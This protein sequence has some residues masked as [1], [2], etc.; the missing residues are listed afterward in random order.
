[1][2][3]NRLPQPTNPIVIDSSFPSVQDYAKIVFDNASAL[4][5]AA[6]SRKEAH[7]QRVTR[8]RNLSRQQKH[9]AVGDVVLLKDLTV[10]KG[11]PNTLKADYKGP[12]IITSIDPDSCSAKIHHTQTSNELKTH[13]DHLKQV[14]HQPKRVR[15]ADRPLL[16]SSN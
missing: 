10:T 13:F 2:F 14:N 4:R 8:Y 5:E 1:M 7:R 12:Y 9:F 6:R 16:S 15:F 3:G 11:S